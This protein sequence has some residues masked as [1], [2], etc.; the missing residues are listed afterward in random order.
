MIN[1]KLEHK[2]MAIISDNLNHDASAV[3]E[4]Q[5]LILN[6]IEKNISRPKKVYYLTDGAGQHF[7]NKSNFANLLTHKEDFKMPAEWHFHPTAHGKGAC[8]GIGANVKRD[9]AKFSLQCSNENQSLDAEA[10]FKWAKS[11]CK[12]TEILYSSKQEHEETAKGLKDKF[13][14]AVTIKGTL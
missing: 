10:L 12:K 8:D 11:N 2:S 3:Y 4:Y 9:A 14:G 5:K 6:Y 13:E 7:K 1:T